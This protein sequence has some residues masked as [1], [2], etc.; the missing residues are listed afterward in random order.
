GRPARRRSAGPHPVDR[1]PE[2]TGE[3]EAPIGAPG[4]FDLE[5]DGLVGP[6]PEMALAV[7]LAPQPVLIGVVA[8]LSEGEGRKAHRPG[9]GVEVL[10]DG[11]GDEG[12]FVANPVEE[13]RQLVGEVFSLR[14]RWRVGRSLPLY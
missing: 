11:F 2:L 4:W 1:L 6:A 10:V 3:L 5:D 14:W 12:R 8:V 7:V 13:Q 9:L